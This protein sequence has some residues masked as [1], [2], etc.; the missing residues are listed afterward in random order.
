MLRRVSGAA[1]CGSHH[2]V[3]FIIRMSGGVV[4]TSFFLSPAL[5]LPSLA[6]A[7][8]ASRPDSAFSDIR[9]RLFPYRP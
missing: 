1:P 8:N 9:R 5:S 4:F 3:P 2:I 6:L 7:L